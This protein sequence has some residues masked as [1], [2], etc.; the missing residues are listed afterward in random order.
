MSGKKPGVVDQA[1]NIV[2]FMLQ[3]DC[4]LRD[5][6]H[7][8]TRLGPYPGELTP[9]LNEIGR[10]PQCLLV[11]GDRAWKI[12]FAIV[13]CAEAYMRWSVLIV[14]GDCLAIVRC[15]FIRPSQHLERERSVVSS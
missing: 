4:V 3:R 6:I 2:R 9:R 15:G 11:L 1:R 12:A 13:H 8:T 10:E 5:G 14:E 7:R